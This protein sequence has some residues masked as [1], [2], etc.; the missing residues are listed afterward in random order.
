MI[1]FTKALLAMAALL[2]L[3]SVASAIGINIVGV[4]GGGAD[5]V[6]APG[7]SITFDLRMTDN[8]GGPN[9]FGLAVSVD[10]YDDADVSGVR[11]GGIALQGGT[12]V[13]QTLGADFGSGPQFGIDNVLSAPVESWE[14]NQFVPNAYTTAL[15]EGVGTSPAAGDGTDDLGINGLPI[16]GDLHFQVTFANA[17]AGF[18]AG[19][20]TVRTLNFNVLTVLDG[21]VANIETTG[22]TLTVIPEPGTALLMGLGLAGL[23]TTR[24]R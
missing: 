13:G 4:S 9:V 16:A 18:G 23:A 10:G 8:V 21:G 11:Q 1:R 6:L 22:F 17:A 2:V 5:G 24:R 7:E 15:F 3:P 19:F 20:S 14:V 12:V